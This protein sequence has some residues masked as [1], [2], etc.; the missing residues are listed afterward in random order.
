MDEAR[1]SRW[2]LLIHQIP[3]KPDYFR[4]K[5]WRRLMRVGA[6]PVKNSVYVLPKSDSTLEDFQWILR[7]ITEGGGD[8]SVCEAGFV[9]GL[10]D[11]QIE[12]LFRAAR[13]ADYAAVAEEARELTKGKHS[14]GS[15]SVNELA[16]AV[17]KLRNRL[18][19]ILTIDYFDSL[20]RQTAEG[21][22]SSLERVVAPSP[23]NETVNSPSEFRGIT[24]V[25]RKGI[26]VDRM[27]SAWLIRRFIDEQANFKFVPARGYQPQKAEVRFDMF[28]AEFTHEGDRC[29]AEI[30]MARFAPNENGLRQVT[31]I[32]HDIDLKDAKFEHPETA[33]VEALITGICS[34]VKDDDE[35]L[36]RGSEVF[37]D[38]FEFF[39]RRRR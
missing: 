38:L 7:E 9:E 14:R 4:V 18:T 3:P 34:R 2:L 27:A 31:E 24:W 37:T 6:V 10:T 16:A 12:S 29:T 30:L 36:T 5:I 33:G 35:R 39:S 13:D 1:D 23:P 26:H 28:D 8:A 32:V 25:T 15:D 19:E 11:A 20:G 22:V 21:L 17:T